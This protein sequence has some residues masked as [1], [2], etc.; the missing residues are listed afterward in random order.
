[1]SDAERTSE[2]TATQ[3]PPY[4]A[5]KTWVTFLDDLKAHGIPDQ[6]DRSVL[7]R[8]AG[9]IAGQLIVGI[10]TLGLI[11]ADN[12]P[13]ARLAELVRALNTDDFKGVLGQM[14]R[15]A[16]PYV[17]KLD[18]TTATPTMFADAFKSNVGAKG[19]D[20]LSKCRRFFLQA[21]HAA[22]I[23][24]GKR[25]VA[26]GSGSP[27]GPRKKRVPKAK[28]EKGADGSAGTG[29]EPAAIPLP[30]SRHLTWTRFW[31]NFRRSTQRGP[32]KS[33]QSGSTVS[34]CS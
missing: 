21:A 2:P 12:K 19:E 11:T 15:D 25:L 8:F 10:R 18:L 1:M 32:T 14:L 3:T 7:K 20:V 17:F 26:R 34:T 23:E 4:I 31:Q 24:V 29:V 16:Y 30:L 27:A 6:I 9:G 28:E 13:T 33:R 5:F 22:D